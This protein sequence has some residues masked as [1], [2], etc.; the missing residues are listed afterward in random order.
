MGSMGMTRF[1][2]NSSQFSTPLGMKRKAVSGISVLCVVTLLFGCSTDK[3]DPKERV[4]IS[5]ADAVQ[6]YG[7]R[8]QSDD[9][10]SS[11]FSEY[12]DESDIPD[13]EVFLARQEKIEE[14]IQ[15]CMNEQGFEYHISSLDTA[16]EE[17]L[18][19]AAN[20]T[21]ARTNKE[22]MEQW[23][24]G[25][26]TMTNPDGTPVA[27]HPT[28]S[29][30][31]SNPNEPMLAAMPVE[32]QNAWQRALNGASAQG[33]PP[34]EDAAQPAETSADP[35]KAAILRD[36][37]CFGLAYAPT[38]SLT[39]EQK[40][41]MSDL[42]IQIG[43]QLIAD[44]R[45]KAASSTYL[46]CVDD[47]G[48]GEITEVPFDITSSAEGTSA[49]EVME[50]K[51]AAL[52]GGGSTSPIGDGSAETTT[53]SFETTDTIAPVDPVEWTALQTQEHTLAS[54]EFPCLAV[55][56][57][58]KERIQNDLGTQIID[59]NKA[60]FEDYKKAIADD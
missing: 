56:V 22:F 60:F 21:P 8:D 32:E 51:V 10:P 48:Y 7:N 54:A 55:F 27:N 20:A 34:A 59:E 37:G 38:D 52:Y 3:N 42:Y 23:G 33:I 44:D 50:A 11:P 18:E 19:A 47:A 5:T 2:T 1:R 14:T 58:E 6:E 43:T 53:T 41:K 31:I 26:T 57:L 15:T 46:Q 4:Q 45:Y 30:G 17:E 13:L 12:L 40:N 28:A 24:Y 9:N 36:V 25:I 29:S 35:E 49:K 16:T 39:D